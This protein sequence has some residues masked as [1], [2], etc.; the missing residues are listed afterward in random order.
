[1]QAIAATTT[2]TGLDDSPYETGVTV[3]GRQMDALPLTR[4][5]WHGDW[6]YTLRPE[7]YDP[8]AGIPEPFDRPS[9]GLAWLCH[10]A[11]TG[12]PAAERDAL[13]GA[14]MSLHDEQREAGLDKRRGHRPRLTA[15]G[16]GRCPVLTLA[17][18]LLAA[19]LHYRLALPQVAVA[20]LFGVR[21]ETVNKRIRDIRQLLDQAG[22]TIQPGPHRLASLD[23]LYQLAT[24][25]GIVIQPEIKTA[26]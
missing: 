26:C 10:P 14:L 1:V 24:S 23:D 15:P 9:P 16:T 13:T 21:P 8:E 3:S 18:R 4:H 22:H 20:A 6:N 5:D 7:A 17:D 25:T 2:R 11:L 12:L 19:I